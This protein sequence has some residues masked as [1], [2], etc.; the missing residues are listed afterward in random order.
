M[1]KLLISEP[2]GIL[3]RHRFDDLARLAAYVCG[4]PIGLIGLIDSNRE[5]F[6]SKVGWDVSEIPREVSIG[7]CAILQ[8][9]VLIVSDTLG[10]IRFARSQLVTQA[11]VR[12]HAGVP[13]LTPEGYAL[14]T[15]SVMDYVPRALTQ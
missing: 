2:D 9:D 10:D 6:K 14:G 5:W 7:T 3:A 12:F 13:L 4:T 11:G 8:H 15:L 1:C